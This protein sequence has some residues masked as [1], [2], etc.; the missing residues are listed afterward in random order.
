MGA[1]AEAAHKQGQLSRFNAAREAVLAQATAALQSGE[2]A[3]AGAL[4]AKI[5]QLDEHIRATQA[6]LTELE[7]LSLT[8]RAGLH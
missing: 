1:T 6:Q 8:E 5:E 3:K 7:Q 4:V 2:R